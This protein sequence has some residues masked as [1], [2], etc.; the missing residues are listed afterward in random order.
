MILSDTVSSTVTLNN[1][2]STAITPSDAM[3]PCG[4]MPASTGVNWNAMAGPT[5]TISALGTVTTAVN[6]DCT[7]A[8]D[9][10]FT[11]TGSDATA[12]T[13]GV[14]GASGTFSPIVGQSIRIRHTASSGPDTLTWT[15][16]TIAWL[17]VLTGAGGTSQSAPVPA[18]SKLCDITLICTG[19]NKFDGSYIVGT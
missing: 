7:L 17:G 15:G 5:R 1:V 4:F 13:F 19:Q 18:A 3:A 8:S 12:V 9:F 11:G 10:T 16:Y 6:L 14:G 2:A